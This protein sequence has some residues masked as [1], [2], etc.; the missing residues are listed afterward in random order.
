[1]TTALGDKIPSACVHVDVVGPLGKKLL[2]L[3]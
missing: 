3:V 1:M 2:Q